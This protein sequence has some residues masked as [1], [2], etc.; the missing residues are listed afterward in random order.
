MKILFIE[1]C[2]FNFGGYFRAINICTA[3]SKKGFS[4]DL[5]LPS[6][7]KFFWKIRKTKINENLTMYELPRFYI[8][9][10]VQG[11]ILRGFIATLFGIFKKYDIVHAAMP[12]E[13]E[14]NIPA[15]ILKIFGKKIVMD[16]DDR[17][18]DGVFSGN[19]ILHMYL[20][21]C[22]HGM[23]KII[24]NYCVANDVLGD[25]AKEYGANNIISI[26]NG[27]NLDQVKVLDKK[28]SRKKLE[29][30][31]ETKYLL[32][33]GNTFSEE[34]IFLL[35]K[36]L[37]YIFSLDKNTKIICTL[38]PNKILENKKIKKFF[39]SKYL[40]RFINVNYI[41][42]NDLGLYLSA[43]DAS[44]FIAGDDPKEKVCFPIRIGTYLCGET[45]I[46]MND[47]NS[48]VNKILDKYKC[49]VID[50]DLEKLAAK[51][52]KMLYSPTIQSDLKKKVKLAKKEL[53][54]DNLVA[55]LI[56]YYQKILND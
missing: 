45:I 40:D 31:N 46:V 29:L 3:L 25:L 14:S 27:V 52:V 51:T 15:L 38:N 22:E 39:N 11:R 21:L 10:F 42:P 50:K 36:T 6:D 2:Y 32:T 49:M 12:V 41:Q 44:V 16:W 54:Y 20:R 47:V 33:F 56:G 5:L 23:P 30:D 53:S 17:F 1:P 48:E 13:F 26:I 24:K 9:F 18:E 19:K 34:R 37:N 4:I 35:F 8:N 43:C 28:Q 55:D 7:K